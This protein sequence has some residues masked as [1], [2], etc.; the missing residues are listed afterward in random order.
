MIL[1]LKNDDFCDS[2][3]GAAC[4]GAAAAVSKNDEFCIKNEKFCI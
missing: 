4:G 3:S 1:R 2:E